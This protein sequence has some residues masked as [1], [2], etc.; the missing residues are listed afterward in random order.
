ME[1][2]KLHYIPKE[3]LIH[4]TEGIC[5][6]ENFPLFRNS[7]SHRELKRDQEYLINMQSHFNGI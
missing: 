4:C 5:L 7:N 2:D 1:Q 3:R 6:K